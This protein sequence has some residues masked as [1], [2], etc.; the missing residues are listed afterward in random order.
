M[1]KHLL[2]TPILAIIACLLWSTAFVG[3]K[4]G[5]QYTTPLQFASIRFFIAGLLIL[6][7]IPKFR[8]KLTIAKQY[9]KKIVFFGLLQTTLLYALFYTGI[10]LVPGALGAMLIG[11]GPLFAAL[12]A[13][14]MMHNDKISW[15]KAIS[16][17]MGMSGIAIISFGRA[18]LMLEGGLILT[19]VLILIANNIVGGFGNVY[20]SKNSQ[21]IPPMVLSSFSLI[22]GGA[23]LFLISLPIEGFQWKSYPPEYYGSL[24]WLS[25]LSATAITI[26]I[27]LLKR[28][29]VKVSDLNMWKFII[30]V[31]GA[32][33]SWIMLPNESAD[34]ISII[35]MIII[36]F[37]LLLLNYFNR[38][39]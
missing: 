7:F 29:Q 15:K 16:I 38:K 26:W 4:I 18:D 20:V 9:W 8:H 6:P 25:I 2:S 19:G 35:G 33:L 27:A 36:A 37:S 39:N 11:S 22:I 10:D 14:F 3:I 17:L 24:A 5:L 12:T 13:H 1:K 31:L 34:L 21:T 28:P 30:P 32:I 23:V